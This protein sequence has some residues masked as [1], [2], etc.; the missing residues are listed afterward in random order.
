MESRL[1]AETRKKE[2]RKEG[3][4]EKISGSLN[5]SR[6]RWP[7]FPT[8]N[9]NPSSS[10]YSRKMNSGAR[11]RFIQAAPCKRHFPSEFPLANNV[12][13]ISDQ[14]PSLWPFVTPCPN[15]LSQQPLNVFL[16]LPPSS[17]SPYLRSLIL[18][19]SLSLSA[20]SLCSERTDPPLS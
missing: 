11:D 13:I 10:L 14:R 9:N 4:K 20:R 8:N 16:S 19:F 6:N 17:S 5:W 15:P 2:G 1:F 18:S 3:R 7:V 12:L